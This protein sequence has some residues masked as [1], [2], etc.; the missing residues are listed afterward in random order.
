MGFFLGIDTSNYTTSFSVYNPL[1]NTVFQS[2]RLLSVESGKLGLR[3]SDALFLHIKQAG[4][5]ISDLLAKTDEKITAI[6]VSTK[7]RNESGSY[8]PCFLAGKAIAKS[9]GAVLRV[10]VYEFSHQ[11]G[12]IMASLYSSEKLDYV[13]QSFIA[14]HVSGGTTEALLV[15]PDEMNVFNVRILSQSLDLKAG[16]AVDRIGAML[17]LSFPA[18]NEL[19][20]LALKSDKT[21]NPKPVMKGINC[22]LSGI[23]NKCR[24]MKDK[25]ESDED[26]A[27]FCLDFIANT[28]IRMTSLLLEQHGCLPVVYAGGV[29]S[30]SIIRSIITQK[31]DNVSFASPEFSSDNASGVLLY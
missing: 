16:Q 25:G 30:N 18:G 8:M 7:P 15:T 5:L 4:D 27:K 21:Y 29:M 24:D 3:Q 6:G 12:H 22:S 31:F 13:N 14:F 10:P 9:C 23:E 11:D 2:K 17:D 26:I 28:I 19:E 1:N 20:S